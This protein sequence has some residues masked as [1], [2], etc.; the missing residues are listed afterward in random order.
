MRGLWI[1]MSTVWAFRCIRFVQ[2]SYTIN[3]CTY[4][5]NYTITS[6]SALL[7]MVPYPI[8]PA[9]TNQLLEAQLWQDQQIPSVETTMAL[10]GQEMISNEPSSTTTSYKNPFLSLSPCLKYVCIRTCF[11]ATVSVDSLCRCVLLDFTSLWASSCGCLCCLKM[12]ATN[13]TSQQAFK[14]VTVVPV[15]SVTLLLFASWPTPRT[16][17]YGYETGW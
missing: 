2:N 14:G 11:N 10:W 1:F 12:P 7:L 6:R 4:T 9:E 16:N 15:M 13:L 5:K 8:Q 3:V 17:C